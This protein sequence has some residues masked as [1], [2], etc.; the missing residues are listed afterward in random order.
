MTKVRK[1]ATRLSEN[2]K[3][4]YD[5][6][7]TSDRPKI[8]RQERIELPLGRAFLEFEDFRL[9]I[10]NFSAFGLLATSDNKA[11][12]YFEDEKTYSEVKLVFEGYE[13]QQLRLKLVRL[14]EEQPEGQKILGFEVIGDPL[15]VEYIL[16]LDM[17]TSV[18]ED[19][20]KLNDDFERIPS[21][22]AAL[23]YKTKDWLENLSS[24]VNALQSKIEADDLSTRRD[25]ERAITKRVSDYLSQVFPEKHQEI[26]RSLE[27]LKSDD[28]RKCV[29]FFRSKLEKLLYQAPFSNRAFYKPKG[30]AGDYEMMNHLY[31]DDFEGE[32]LFAK[33][34]HH[35]F[36]NEPAA[37]AVRNR[38]IY[39]EAKLRGLLGKL[40]QKKEGIQILS[41]ASGPAREIQNILAQEDPLHK[42]AV[43]FTFLDQDEDSLK[44]AQKALRIRD[45][46]LNTNFRYAFI[47]K[48]LRKV[49]ARGLGENEYDLIYSAGLF[50]YLTDPVAQLA[51]A[52]LFESLT[53]GGKLIIGNFNLDNPTLP[54]M[55]LALDWS[56][57]Y[58]SEEDLI[59]LFGPLSDKV[60]VEKED[61]GINLF[62]VIEK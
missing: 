54:L 33:A 16:G 10:L 34:L 21:T 37:Q 53:P 11:S 15:K 12:S 4:I 28:L 24:T 17:V 7:K 8:L 56:L 32:T 52:K 26:G 48:A 44:F 59:R 25:Y 42:L 19:Q 20:D 27:G 60:Y 29:D 9:S 46:R 31:R 57:I 22:F 61:L 38:A 51:A 43:D 40:S 47:N 2:F 6:P 41:V 36:V 50:D 18:I 49:I 55:D 23:V 58:R 62:C 30:Y 3:M 35:Y 1:D 39:L 45:S 5:T 13:I 14:G